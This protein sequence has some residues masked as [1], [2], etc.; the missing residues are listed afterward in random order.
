MVRLGLI[1]DHDII[2]PVPVNEAKTTESP[3]F[4]QGRPFDTKPYHKFGAEGIWATGAT[5]ILASDQRA[6]WPNM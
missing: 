1:M 3:T 6:W 2:E 4:P 5:A